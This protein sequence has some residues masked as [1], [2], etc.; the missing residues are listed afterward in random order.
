LT[1][2][3]KVGVTDAQKL[4]EALSV[5]QELI[6]QEIHDKLVVLN[7]TDT[8][9]VTM[10]VNAVDVLL[11]D[12]TQLN[13]KI[14]YLKAILETLRA[15]ERGTIDLTTIPNVIFKAAVSGNVET[16]SQQQ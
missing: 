9:A 2:G 8:Q 16:T 11:G 1:S 5:L 13:Y 6:D 3:T 12:T 4:N 14:K 15:E 7:M 10:K